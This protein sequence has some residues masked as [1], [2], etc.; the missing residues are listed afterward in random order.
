MTSPVQF[1]FDF[2]SPYAY[3]AAM[4]IDQL[5]A[6]YGREVEWHPILLGIVFKTTGTGPLVTLPLKGPYARHDLVR[7]ARFH[8]IPF[9]IPTVFPIATQNAARA[10]LWIQQQHGK[11]VAKQF[12]IAALQA[13]F[14]DDIT[15]GDIEPVVQIAVQC[16]LDPE[17]VA[18]GLQ[19]QDIKDQ[20]RFNV[21]AAIERGIFGAPYIVIDDEPFWGFDRFDQIEATLKNGKI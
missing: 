8:Q 19:Q 18:A 16:G 6:K 12:A 15:I 4:R 9:I 11:A 21:D 17:L 10:M 1:Y 20:L 2:S 5:A 13:Y 7:S 3:L 14:V